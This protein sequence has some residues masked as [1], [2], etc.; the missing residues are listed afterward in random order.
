MSEESLKDILD[1]YDYPLSED[2][3]AN[4]PVFPR[5]HSK[6][7]VLNR[8]NAQIKDAHFY[9]LLDFLNDKDVLVLNET[10][11]FSARLLGKKQS[12]GKVELLLIKQVDLYTFEAISKPGLKLGQK[13]FFPRRSF[14]ESDGSLSADLDIADFL[15]AEVIFREQDSAKVRVKFNQSGANLLA[16]IDLCGFTPLPPYIH[17]SQ[18]EETIKEEYQTVYAKEEGSA[19]APTAG[20][21]FTDELLKKLEDKGVQIEKVTLHVGLGTF[22]KLTSE[23]IKNKTLHSEYYE[24][25]AEVADRLNQAKKNGKRI[26][27][28]GTTSTRTLES[29][30]LLSPSKKELVAS[31]KETNI[32]IDPPYQF[33]FIDALITNFHLPKSSLLMLVSAF[34][35]VPNTSHEFSDFLNSS[36]GKA[37]VHALK[38]DYRFFSFGDAMLIVDSF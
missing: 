10:K 9:D 22:A 36:V 5:D 32:F 33:N 19:A 16:E 28:V 1:K 35:S 31:A 12:G 13:L 3:I 8:G 34:C 21:H 30:V 37:Y 18:S 25:S 23:N 4:Q 2:R 38:N 29:A 11:V 20:L 17:P 15:Q 14:L 7:L 26:V 6:L 27:A 24:V